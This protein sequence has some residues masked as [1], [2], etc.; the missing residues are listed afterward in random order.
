MHVFAYVKTGLLVIS[1]GFRHEE[2]SVSGNCGSR[3]SS[4]AKESAQKKRQTLCPHFFS[5][6]I[7][8]NRLISTPGDDFFSLK[9]WCCFCNKGQ[10]WIP[11]QQIGRRSVKAEIKVGKK[12]REKPSWSR[13]KICL[14]PTYQISVD[15]RILFQISHSFTHI[16]A[17][18]QQGFLWK[19]APLA[20]EVVRQ[21]AV[22]HELKHQADGSVLKAHTIKLD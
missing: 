13:G 8:G 19:T 14:G 5:N 16:L 9:Y 6:T 1:T 21:A 7:K 3:G 17:H 2:W 15:D 10:Y 20:P 18:P 22:L 4:G 11:C 12:H